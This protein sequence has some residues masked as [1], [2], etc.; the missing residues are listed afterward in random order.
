[1][2]GLLT[3]RAPACALPAPPLKQQPPRNQAVT[4]ERQQAAHHWPPALLGGQ[5]DILLAGAWVR[6]GVK[7]CEHHPMC[8]TAVCPPLLQKETPTWSLNPLSPLPTLSAHHPP[9]CPAYLPL[10]SFPPTHLCPPPT[11]AA[12]S[13]SPCSPGLHLLKEASHMS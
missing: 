4:G 1:M 3:P 7:R 13:P 11:P 2:L 9:G 5:G 6:P 10:T 8:H 12:P